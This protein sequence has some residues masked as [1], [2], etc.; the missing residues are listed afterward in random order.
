MDIK[1]IDTFQNYVLIGNIEE[2]KWLIQDFGENAGST[3]MKLQ[4]NSYPPIF[5]EFR[6]TS[7]NQNGIKQ[8]YD[9]LIRKLSR[10]LSDERRDN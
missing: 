7:F 4:K 2:N 10:I 5:E 8:E 9:S 1:Y 3:F 6:E